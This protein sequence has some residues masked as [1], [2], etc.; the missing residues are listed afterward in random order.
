MVFPSVYDM[1]NA[2]MTTVRKQH[3]WE[4]FSGATLNSRWTTGTVVGSPTSYMADEI[5]GG[6]VLSS[7]SP[8]SNVLGYINFNNK[9]QYNARSSVCISVFKGSRIIANNNFQVGTSNTNGNSHSI[10]SGSHSSYTTN[11]FQLLTGDGSITST[12]STVPLDVNYHLHKIENSLSNAKLYL[13]GNLAVTKTTNRPTLVQ[14][15]YAESQAWG[16][17]GSVLLNIKYMEVYN[18]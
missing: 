16:S 3:F 12:E 1:T 2:S 7:V 11:N 15:P 4:Y 6:F 17:G 13:D 5:D 8:A 14:Q 9:T 10:L 18:V